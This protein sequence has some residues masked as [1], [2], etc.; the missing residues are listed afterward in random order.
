M[1]FPSPEQIKEAADMLDVG[2]G[3]YWN[4]V[5]GQLLFIPENKNDPFNEYVEEDENFKELE[6]HFA[7]YIKIDKP[8]S[9]D[10]FEIMEGFAEELTD[11]P[12]LQYELFNA[13]NR[14]KPFREFKFVIDNSGLYRKEWFDFKAAHQQRLLIEKFKAI[15]DNQNEDLK[16]GQI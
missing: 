10:G 11:N 12:K 2:F 4:K 5:T 14:K 6:E 8:T 13:L 9:R 7:D 16:H 15:M 1:K 3:C